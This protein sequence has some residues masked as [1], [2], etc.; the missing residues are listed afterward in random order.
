MKVGI[1]HMTHMYYMQPI[2]KQPEWDSMGLKG[3]QVQLGVQLAFFFGS[4]NRKA[5]GDLSLEI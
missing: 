4:N 1:T 3:D 2:C 5:S